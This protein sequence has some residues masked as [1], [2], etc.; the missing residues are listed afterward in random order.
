MHAL[1]GIQEIKYKK[2]KNKTIIIIIF[3][4]IV[5]II[6]ITIIT[7]FSMQYDK[8]AI[9][10]LYIWALWVSWITYD[11]LYRVIMKVKRRFTHNVSMLS[12]LLYTGPGNVLASS[13]DKQTSKYDADYWTTISPNIFWQYILWQSGLTLT[14]HDI[15]GLF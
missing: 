3:I 2:P 12:L 7:L 11:H 15:S 13:A 9:Y 8:Y 4:T 1:V 5:V 10:S 6:I 14:S